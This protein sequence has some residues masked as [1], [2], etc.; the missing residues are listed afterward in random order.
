[1]AAAY[2]TERTM[3][4]DQP[5]DFLSFTLA[6]LEYGLDARQVRELCLFDAL[7]RFTDGARV[8]PGVARARGVIMPLVDL[9]AAFAG[10][11]VPFEAQSDVIILT[12][13]HCV[14]GMV[15]DGVNGMVTLRP[16]QVSAMPCVDGVAPA[17][18]LLGVGAVGERRLILVDIDRLMTVGQ[19]R[20]TLTV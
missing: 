2:W 13:S 7:E 14:M 1:M 16:D 6:G 4:F 3:P 11:P 19:D 17:D 8:V 18:Y 12:L 20:A 15:V 5:Q 10:H 9:R